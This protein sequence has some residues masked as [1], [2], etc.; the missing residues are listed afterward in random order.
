[1]S[2]GSS[3][4]LNR[5]N[6]ISLWL[7]LMSSRLSKPLRSS[8]SFGE[9]AKLENSSPLVASGER[10]DNRTDGTAAK[11]ISHKSAGHRTRGRRVQDRSDWHGP[12]QQIG[13]RA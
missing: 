6:S 4:R 2:C 10:K 9:F 13:N 1:M 11:G 3:T 7:K 8:L 12:A 5:K